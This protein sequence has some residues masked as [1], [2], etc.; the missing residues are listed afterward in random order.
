[1]SSYL[2]QASP[3]PQ[4]CLAPDQMVASLADE[5][6]EAAQRPQIRGHPVSGE[7]VA[8]L[9]KSQGVMDFVTDLRCHVASIVS[10]DS[11]IVLPLSSIS[12]EL[13]NAEVANL[14][15]SEAIALSLPKDI[16]RL[17]ISMEDVGASVVQIS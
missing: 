10:N 13:G 11:S 9:T 5:S 4:L 6:D 2:F 3:P 8:H 15:G 16:F 12:E 17:E 7:V 1:M 14:P